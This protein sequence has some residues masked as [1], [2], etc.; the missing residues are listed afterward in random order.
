MSTL[1]ISLLFLQVKMELCE[2]SNYSV[3]NS[4]YRARV[5]LKTTTV[6][7]GAEGLYAHGPICLMEY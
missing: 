1:S 7:Q 5:L 2:S 4:N 6:F 3:H